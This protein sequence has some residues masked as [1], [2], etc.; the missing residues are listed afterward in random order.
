MDSFERLVTALSRARVKFVV[1]GLAGANYYVPSGAALFVTQDR[2][3]FLP[4][5]PAVVLAGWRA[6]ESVR[7]ELFRSGEPLDRP[8]DRLLAERVVANRAAVSATDH[9]GLRVD[10]TLEMSG[11]DFEPVWRERRIFRVGS[12]RVPVA[13]L[14][15]IVESKR[16]TGRDKDRLFLA[17]HAGALREL[18][19]A[20]HPLRRRT[21][22]AARPERRTRMRPAGPKR[23]KR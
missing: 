9:A 3:L 10:F 5:D 19:A 18:V 2:D 15:H 22:P 13:R 21:S 20:D 8:R 12:A 17:T 11:F 4:A 7:L 14:A 6:A 23:T 16:R 1:I